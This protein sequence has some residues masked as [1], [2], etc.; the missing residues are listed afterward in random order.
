MVGRQRGGEKEVLVLE[1]RRNIRVSFRSFES[2]E[3]QTF[4][5]GVVSVV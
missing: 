2:A 5:D 1:A 3:H 4:H